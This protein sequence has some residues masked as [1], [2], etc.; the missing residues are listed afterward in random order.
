MLIGLHI[1]CIR[2]VLLANLFLVRFLGARALH[3][4]DLLDL[5]IELFS[6]ESERCIYQAV[7]AT[8]I[9]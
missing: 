4:Y 2:I 5:E 7:N 6:R 9:H 8:I 3:V 1:I